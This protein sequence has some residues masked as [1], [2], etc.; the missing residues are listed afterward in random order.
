MHY[1]IYTTLST[2]R[3]RRL[4]KGNI[5]KASVGKAEGAEQKRRPLVSRLGLSG[6]ESNP[7][8]HLILYF[9]LRLDLRDR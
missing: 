9:H 3:S 6:K 5:K 7:R 1:L 2:T 8:R 4:L